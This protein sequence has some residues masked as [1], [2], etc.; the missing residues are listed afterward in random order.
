M[1]S[2]ERRLVFFSMTL[3]ILT[4]GVWIAGG[5]RFPTKIVQASSHI[6]SCIVFP[7]GGCYDEA[8]YGADISTNGGMAKAT[9]VQPSTSSVPPAGSPWPQNASNYCFLAAVQAIANYQWWVYSGSIPYPNQS[10][11]G[12]SSGKVADAKSPQILWQMQQSNFIPIGGP[13]NPYNFTKSNSSG[14][15]GGDPR[16]Q[17]AGAFRLTP[18]LHYY[19]QYIYHQGNGD[20]SN[21]ATYGLAKGVAFSHS[22]GPSPEIAI[23]DHGLH[24]VV[25]AGVWSY[26]NP[27][28]ISDAGLMAFAVYNPWN[29]NWNTYLSGSY[30]S[31]VSVSDWISSSPSDVSAKSHGVW[32]GK[33]Y[34]SN[35]GSDPDPNIWI[36]KEPNSSYPHHWISYY[37]SIQRDDDASD[38][39][40]YC[41]DENGN[42]MNHP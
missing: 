32:W 42:V 37:V 4:F 41:H 28:S 16:T 38:S 24:S 25:V 18:P 12:N 7:D 26:G 3:L 31:Q 27:S 19:H 8:Y 9:G 29:Q 21:G 22:N 34:D 35:S 15:Y 39:F 23:V 10:S 40:E 1:S 17:V 5:G 11:Q 30:Y 13:A 6:P 33:P 36:Y 2:V 20:T 14:D